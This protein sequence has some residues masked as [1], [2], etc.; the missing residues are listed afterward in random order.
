VGNKV[1]QSKFHGHNTVHEAKSVIF[2]SC[3]FYN[4]ILG[5][6]TLLS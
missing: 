5:M 4:F 1:G 2:I 6:L 3:I